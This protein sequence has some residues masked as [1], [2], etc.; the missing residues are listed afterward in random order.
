ML[1]HGWRKI[2]GALSPIGCKNWLI[3]KEIKY[4]GRITN[5]KRRKVS[6]LDTRTAEQIASGGMHGGDRMLWHGYATHYAQYL[7]PF[8]S[9][10]RDITLIEIGILKGHGLAIWC[11]L[12]PNG[13]IYG[14]DIDLSY[15]ND[16]YQNLYQKGAFRANE[17]SLYEFD[18]FLDN[19]EFVSQLLGLERINVCIDDGIHSDQAILTTIKSIQPSLAKHFVYFVEDNPTVSDKISQLWP[20]YCVKSFG[21]LTIITSSKDV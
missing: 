19:K 1:I 9:Q 17:P 10:C 4:G 20:E 18:Q 13:N 11:D 5:V 16:N 6:N 2:L 14:F 15:F 8:L 12:F 21:E 7:T 3:A